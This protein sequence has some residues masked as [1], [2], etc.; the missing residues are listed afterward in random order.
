L[1]ELLLLVASS[2]WGNDIIK[3]ELV[4]QLHAKN[5]HLYDRESRQLILDDIVSAIARDDL[6]ELRGFG[7]FASKVRSARVGRNRMKVLY[8]YFKAGASL[9]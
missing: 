9:S 4:K 5:S 1:A 6:V 3:S 7:T 2:E 8:P